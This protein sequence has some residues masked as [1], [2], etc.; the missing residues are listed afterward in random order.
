M[1]SLVSW[2]SCLYSS[3]RALI[4]QGDCS[5]EEGIDRGWLIVPDR[6]KGLPSDNL[7]TGEYLSLDRYREWGSFREDTL[8]QDCLPLLLGK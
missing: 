6:V 1:D 4:S 7:L 3:W 2:F 5:Q 8:E